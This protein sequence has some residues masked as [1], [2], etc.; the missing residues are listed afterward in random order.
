MI[1]TPLLKIAAK[2][3]VKAAK[4]L[5]EQTPVQ[6]AAAATAAQFTECEVMPSLRKWCKSDEFADLLNRFKRGDRS[7]T[8]TAVMRS[9]IS[10]SGFYNANDTESTAQSILTAFDEHL[11]KEIYNSKEGISTLASR[12]EELHIE[13]REE[14]RNLLSQNK[15][16]IVDQVS[17]AVKQD[18]ASILAAGDTAKS[19]DLQDKIFGAR[20]ED[21]R[22]LLREGRFRSARSRLEII[23]KEAA[24]AESSVLSQFQIATNLA[25]CAIQLDELET[26]KSE[27]NVALTLRPNDPEAVSYAAFV[28]ARLGESERA[29]ELLATAISGEVKHPQIA[30]TIVRVMCIL[31]KLAEA[32]LFLLAHEDLKTSADCLLALGQ[33][34]YDEGKFAEAETLFRQAIENGSKG[35]FAHFFLGLSILFPTRESLNL[36]PRLRWRI[37][38][39]LLIRL[40]KAKSELTKALEL[41]STFED[42]S[43][44]RDALINRAA[45]HGL[46]NDVENGLKD[47]HAVL[48]EDELNSA[49]LRNK[50]MLLSKIG[51]YSE[52]IETFEK[53][54]D[55][56]ERAGFAVI[57]ASNYLLA[58]RPKDT[59]RILEPLLQSGKA[60][61]KEIAIAE[62]LISAYDKVGNAGAIEKL[63][64]DLQAADPANADVIA[65][66]AEARLRERKLDLAVA[67]FQEAL[68]YS[69]GAQREIIVLQ[70]AEVYF[71]Q[72]NW[73]E[74][75]A[76]YAE[77]VDTTY[78][79]NT[80][81]NY[82]VALFNSGSRSEAFKLAKELRADGVPIPTVTEVE[83]A[84]LEYIG[85]LEQAKQLY[86]NLVEAEP[87]NVSHPIKAAMIE[88]RRN[89]TH[90]ARALIEAIPYSYFKDD[91]VALMRVAEM[92]AALRM[93]QVLP[94]AYRARQLGYS[95]EYT[96]LAYIRLFLNRETTDNQLLSVEDEVQKDTTVHLAR[97]NEKFRFTILDDGPI[98]RQRDEIS[99]QDNLAKKLLGR[100]KG[101]VVTLK[102]SPLEQLSYEITDVQSK[103]VSAFQESMSNFTTWFPDNPALNRFE[104]KDQDVSGIFRQLDRHYEAV[105]EALSIYRKSRMPFALFAELTGRSYLDVW[106]GMIHDSRGRLFSSTGLNEDTVNETEI[107]AESNEIVLD[108]SSLLTISRL[109]LTNVLAKRFDAILVSQSTLDILTEE[110][111]NLA[112]AGTPR[113]IIG[114]RET[115][116]FHY[117][118]SQTDRDSWITFLEGA[119]EFLINLTKTIPV[120]KSLEMTTESI[121][122]M[123]GVLGPSG[124]TSV[125]AA[126]ERNLPLYS[127]D[128][129]LRKLAQTEWNV[130]SFCTSSLLADL[131]AKSLL[132]TDEYTTAI[133]QLILS[134]YRHIGVSANDLMWVL[135][136]DQSNNLTTLPHVMHALH[137]PECDEDS[138]VGVGADFTRLVWVESLLFH[139][140]LVLLDL[141]I[142][143]LTTGRSVRPV[144]A[145]FKVA[146]RQRFALLPL[147]LHV[148]LQNITLWEQQNRLQK[149]LVDQ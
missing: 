123:E 6:R 28:A 20:I 131:R 148:I 56:K 11:S 36:T 40:E 120:Q 110:L 138:A 45:I 86:L 137:G 103:Y 82:I 136:D 47:C 66:T 29:S 70:L 104:V 72:K 78:F 102:D 23:R 1:F 35:P 12:Q 14:T 94:L 17:N 128:L 106:I 21:A 8:S 55:E 41:F 60:D 57:L 140:K 24:A 18:I 142:S 31:G 30:S 68:A 75:A 37:P 42:P 10:V 32:E 79:S 99:L 71:R 15:K 133:R 125:L 9:F 90:E 63:L 143:T 22:Q 13:T 119:K 91:P 38:K 144:L 52:A 93:G 34:K 76:L 67:L 87:Q 117:E 114:R 27:V 83:A 4:K 89:N 141:T 115:G 73:G 16:D 132:S 135:R 59:V 127:D 26:A 108:L 53:V 5:F 77:I 74:A 39:E 25:L 50:G 109:K 105:S 19:T 121:E 96:H 51:R 2:V 81:R 54:V 118:V 98:D 7:I 49:A 92:R 124:A 97:D 48:S 46:L 107:L 65:L 88:L 3:G 33:C 101:D 147:Q 61:P 80:L 129:G 95:R 111:V 149:G 134:N 126:Q 44:R 58:N 84:A 64:A 113:A 62:L 122:Q 139:Q 130:A 100:R 69:T 85:D 146:L 112:G 116:Y 43:Y 145:K